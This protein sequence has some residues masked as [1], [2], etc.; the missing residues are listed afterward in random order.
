MLETARIPAFPPGSVPY[1][2]VVMTG[3]DLKDTVLIVCE[4]IR[5][6]VEVQLKETGYPGEIVWM[7]KSL[8]EYPDQLRAAGQE[9]IDKWQDKPYILLGFGLCGNGLLG[10][11]SEKATLVIP[12]FDDCIRMLQCLEKDTPIRTN[13][14]SLYYTEGW[15]EGM[16]DDGT[17]SMLISDK[18]QQIYGEKKGLRIMKAMLKNYEAVTFIDTGLYDI[19]ACEDRVRK[20]CGALGL[21]TLRE[22][23]TLRIFGKLLQGEWDSEFLVI[24]P[25]HVTDLADFDRRPRCVFWSLGSTESPEEIVD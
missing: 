22:P 20:N 12:A 15:L 10:V 9:V 7:K 14:R 17:E 21:V 8:H 5:N 6:E 25:G 4:M 13:S 18:Y 19:E 3:I 23:G 16:S 24:P 11:R 2:W 1:L